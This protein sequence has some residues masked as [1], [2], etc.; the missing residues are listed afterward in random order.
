MSSP[1]GNDDNIGLVTPDRPTQAYLQL[2][3]LR[4]GPV[5]QSHSAYTYANESSYETDTDE[6]LYDTT[7]SR[8][9]VPVGTDAPN[10]PVEQ[11]EPH[12]PNR[13]TVL[14]S[15]DAPP[16][17]RRCLQPEMEEPDVVP[18]SQAI[19]ITPERPTVRAATDAPLRPVEPHRTALFLIRMLQAL[20]PEE[21]NQLRRENDFN[22]GRIMSQDFFNRDI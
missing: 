6:D 3:P 13:P 18:S 12:T 22:I 19:P 15:V 9:T 17:K 21:F 5:R 7:P 16:P 14:T 8:Q 1:N 11:E 2:A 20:F 10:R 4:V